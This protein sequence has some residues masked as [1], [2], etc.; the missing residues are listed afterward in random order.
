M[1]LPPH[2]AEPSPAALHALIR[3]HPLATLIVPTGAEP[4]A[5]HIPLRLHLPADGAGPVLLRGHVARA[6]PLWRRLADAP[7]GAA[8]ALAI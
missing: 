4:D 7:E 6:N 1:Y 2:F 8:A 3:A 5:D